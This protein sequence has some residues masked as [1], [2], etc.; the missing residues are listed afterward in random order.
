LSA[1]ALLIG[2]DFASKLERARLRTAKVLELEATKVEE[3]G[4]D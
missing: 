4:E 1:A 3:G 2:D